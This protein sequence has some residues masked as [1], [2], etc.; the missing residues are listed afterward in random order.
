ML[1]RENRLVSADDFRTTM[2]TGRK[3]ASANLVTYTKRLETSIPAK[4]GF[5]V[6]KSVGNAVVRNSVKRRLRAIARTELTKIPNNWMV[7]V[8]ALDTAG[9]ATF[10]QL[11]QELSAAV[12]AAVE[13]PSK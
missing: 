5:V 7:V 3:T 12:N 4:F 11:N 2:R 9:S 8:R 6:A 1:A 10:N 13:G